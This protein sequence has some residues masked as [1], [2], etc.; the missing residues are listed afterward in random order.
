MKLWKR[1]GLGVGG[2]VLAG[3][4]AFGASF[5]W[6]YPH[7]RQQKE[8]RTVAVQTAGGQ[9]RVMSC[10]LRCLNPLDFGKKNWFY[11]ADLLLDGVVQAAP[12]VIGFQE[13]TKWQ[14][15]Y[16]CDVLPEY[17]S[18]IT[19]RDKT[20]NSE[21][22]P[23]FYR[24]DRY[25]LLDEGSFWLSET[26]GEMS[27]DWDAACYRICSYVVLEEKATGAQFAVFNTH[28]DHVSDLA[29]I[30]GIHVVLDKM[31][32]I[33]DLPAVLMGDMNA[34]ESS[35][36]YK[37]ATESFLDA[38]YQTENA[39]TGATYQNWGE[40]LQNDCIDYI[41]TSKTGFAVES[42]RV[43]SETQNGVYTSDHF[44]LVAQLRLTEVAADA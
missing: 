1:I 9:V 20:V 25:T 31:H 39:V 21:G 44:P 2:A 4:L 43:L 24:A 32:E 27:K 37:S 35:D 28:L 15:A 23:V 11:R 36:T 7:Y 26:P 22:C 5:V 19:Y 18:V 3:L 12:D 29:R 40:A 38:K 17:K 13:A 34:T 10:N 6:Y 8:A 16:L 41:F 33:G 30:N 14:Y 42:F